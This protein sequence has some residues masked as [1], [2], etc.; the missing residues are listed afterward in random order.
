M[1]SATRSDTSFATIF[2]RRDATQ[3]S[4][5][6]TVT[7]EGAKGAATGGTLN[8]R[9]SDISASVTGARV[10]RGGD[11]VSGAVVTRS[12]PESTSTTPLRRGY[13]NEGSVPESQA[14]ARRG[15]DQDRSSGAA[16]SLSAQSSHLASDITRTT[17]EPYYST[18][19]ANVKFL[20]TNTTN[21]TT[22]I[23]PTS[24]PTAEPRRKRKRNRLEKR[25][26]KKAESNLPGT[27]EAA[28]EAGISTAS[29]DGP[30]QEVA[31]GAAMTRAS[32]ESAVAVDA[33]KMVTIVREN[34]EPEASEELSGATVTRGG[35]ATPAKV[36]GPAEVEELNGAT[37]TR[38]GVYAAVKPPVQQQQQQQQDQT[39]SGATVNRA[40]EMHGAS[41]KARDQVSASVT[42]STPISSPKISSVTRPP[43]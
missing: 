6:A 36:S 20:D 2:G 38:S 17:S 41:V 35:F 42:R 37:V 39:L 7:R 32:P 19:L 4:I 5:S 3:A 8:R 30:P 34:S 23:E 10:T 13:Y 27:A 11:S 43:T 1:T 31:T 14:L 15:G 22:S 26:A 16:I 18:V 24:A 33:A 12:E 25:N 9:K 40:T 21:A 29:V 28:T